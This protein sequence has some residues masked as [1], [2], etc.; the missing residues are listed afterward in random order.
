[1]GVSEKENH[2]IE[3][4]G[5]L[6]PSSY[7]REYRCQDLL[8]EEEPSDADGTA[9]QGPPEHLTPGVIQ[10][11]DSVENTQLVPKTEHIETPFLIK[12]YTHS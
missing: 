5:Q 7:F 11:V 3:I 2:V 1:M 10:Q 8:C 12:S 6:L 4:M 9:S